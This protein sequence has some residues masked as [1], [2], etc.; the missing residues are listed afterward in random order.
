MNKIDKN[1]KKILK[2]NY[3]KTKIFKE[4]IIDNLLLFQ[5]EEYIYN[6]HSI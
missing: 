5:D 4:K 6:H 2:M 3:Q 1:E